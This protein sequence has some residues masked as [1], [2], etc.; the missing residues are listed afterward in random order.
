MQDDMDRWRTS[1]CRVSG[2]TKKKI[3]YLKEREEKLLATM[4]RHDI[5]NMRDS[6]NKKL[7]LDA[8]SL[9][10]RQSWPTLGSLDQ[11]IDADV[12]LPQTILNHHEY[13]QKLQRLALLSD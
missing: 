10:Q 6:V 2:A 12:I 11:K 9:E 1:I 3:T 7:M 13:Q 8:M 4:K 5:N